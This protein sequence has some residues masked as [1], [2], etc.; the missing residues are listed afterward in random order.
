VAGERLRVLL[1]EDHAVVRE[2]T[3][4]ILERDPG[5][6]VIGEAADGAAAVQLVEELRPDIVLLDLALPV[7]NGIEAT[8]QIR[9]GV[10]PPNVLLLSAY[11]DQDYVVSAIEAGASGYLL[12]TASAEDVLAAIRAVA[13]GEVVLHPVAAQRL[14]GRARDSGPVLTDRELEVVR[15]AAEGCGNR[16]IAES[17]SLSMRTV[18]AHFTSVFNK[19]GATNRTEAIATAAARGWLR[20]SRGTGP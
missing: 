20:D 5:I 6:A 18:E 15:M 13:H 16:Q 11:D 19:L 9:A 14:V 12:K 7:M 1:V 10:E 8:R 2:G 3:R 4:R 17:L